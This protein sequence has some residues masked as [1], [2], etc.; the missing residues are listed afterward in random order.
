M[1]KS[2]LFA[3]ALAVAGL[4]AVALGYAAPQF[5][6][7]WLPQADRSSIVQA[8]PTPGPSAVAVADAALP[9]A[10]RNET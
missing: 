4:G 7:A 9:H 10:S 5:G 6:K 1:T 3:S 8:P 2:R